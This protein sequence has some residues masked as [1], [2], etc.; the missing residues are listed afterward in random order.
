M[1]VALGWVAP[2]TFTSPPSTALVATVAEPQ[3]EL[4]LSAPASDSIPFLNL[5]IVIK[6]FA[7]PSY[8]CSNNIL[9]FQFPGMDTPQITVPED[10][11]Q[12]IKGPI[13]LPKADRLGR[14]WYEI[15]MLR[16]QQGGDTI[17][18]EVPINS[19]VVAADLRLETIKG[20]DLLPTKFKCRDERVQAPLMS[21]VVC[22]EE[23]GLADRL[24]W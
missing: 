20:E 16:P 10:F 21:Q 6:C 19:R 18:I 14:T 9:K 3:T 4:S 22:V 12:N 23:S 1:G 8:I 24:A 17:V 13:W 2:Y 11:E 15:E 5:S 7:E